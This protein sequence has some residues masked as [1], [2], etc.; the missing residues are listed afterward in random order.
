M[1]TLLRRDDVGRWKE[2]TRAVVPSYTSPHSVALLDDVDGSLVASFLLSS[3]RAL[4]VVNTGVI[5]LEFQTGRL[6]LRF[7]S[8]A[9]CEVFKQRMASFGVTVHNATAYDGSAPRL[10]DP[11][12]QE[13][14]LK[15]LFSEGFEAFVEELKELLKGMQAK[16]AVHP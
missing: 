8:E 4:V 5:V 3:L 2:R 16:L 12:V 1:C 9:G 13:F 7:H 10:G 6:A 11:R 14:I 15:Q